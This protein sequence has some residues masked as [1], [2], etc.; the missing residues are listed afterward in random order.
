MD[1]H[2]TA[3]SPLT[4]TPI[5][6]VNSS[7]RSNSSTNLS[8]LSQQEQQQLQQ[9]KS[10]DQV[11]RA[12]EAAHVAAGSGIVRGGANFSF[13]RGPD[14]VQYAVGGEVTIDASKV[15]GDPQATIQKAQ[16]IQAAALAPAQPST[17]DRNVAAKAAQMAIEARAEISQQGDNE[18]TS[19]SST[20][21]FTSTSA[22]DLTG[23]LLDLTA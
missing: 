7:A 11:V 21:S 4:T 19:S 3:A 15:A 23:N 10:R 17:Q 13:Q 6:R 2:A 20:P 16:Q 1:T 5:I 22:E 8:E 12:H 18:E 9:L 14:G